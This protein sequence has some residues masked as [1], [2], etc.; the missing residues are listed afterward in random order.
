MVYYPRDMTGFGRHVPAPPWPDDAKL[1]VQFVVN[2]EEG[3]ERCLL[4]GSAESES[5]LS[6]IVG[7][8]PWPGQRHWNMESIYEYG[9]RTGF[10]RL[11]E[12]FTTR[13]VPVTVFGV[14]TALARAPEQVAAM[15]QAGWE[16]ASHG[17]KWID[18]KDYTPDEER[19]EIME[20]IRLHQAVVGAS[21]RGWYTGRCSDHTV[22]LVAE[23][24]ICTYQADS[25][26]DDTPYYQDTP[27]GPQLMIPYTLDAND[28]RFATPQGFNSGKQF[29]DYLRD[30]F[31][32]LYAEGEAGK[33]RIM[34][35]GLHCR[36]AG[37]PGRLQAVQSFLDYAIQK[38]GVWFATRLSIAECWQAAYP[39]KPRYRPSQ[40]TKKDFIS[41]FGSVFEH[42]AWVAEQAYDTEI[43]PS[44]DTATGLHS[45]LCR[46]FRLA[47]PKQRLEV[48]SAHPDLAGKLAKAKQLTDASTIE[49]SSAGLDVLTEAQQLAF[50][51]LNEAY[52][53]KFDFP[54]IL[55]V[56]GLSAT[57]IKSI[58]EQRLSN[59]KEQEFEEACGQVEKIA[60][61]RIEDI[62]SN[63]EATA[64]NQR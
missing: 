60:R 62:F 38:T 59:P 7:A 39:F 25:Y 21:P 16:I 53:E 4:H 29:F 23:Q 26:A 52:R 5:C 12:L 63:M 46:Q 27:S 48:L 49:Q 57:E 11:Y 55:A 33:A 13:K 2:Y 20:A 64:T 22:D 18:Y 14:A 58:F 45:A 17:L 51:D 50:T 15:K 56:K 10:W 35:I 9:A 31:D 28:M 42:S 47:S 3:G 30:T 1:A 37:R 32:V 43:S 6:E 36:L 34:N 44:I 40:M 24:G 19:D 41:T 61:L 8:A 54:F